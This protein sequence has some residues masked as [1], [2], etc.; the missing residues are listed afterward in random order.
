MI[1]ESCVI[2]QKKTLVCSKY[3][4]ILFTLAFAQNNLN[5]SIMFVVFA[6]ADSYHMYVQL[7]RDQR[8]RNPRYGY[9]SV[10]FMYNLPL[11]W[12]CAS[13]KN[14][15]TAHAVFL[16]AHHQGMTLICFDSFRDVF[17]YLLDCHS[18]FLFHMYKWV[19]KS[20]ELNVNSWITERFSQVLKT[21]CIF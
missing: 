12:K 14:H 2:G 1:R 20:W 9:L 15:G 7:I 4:T 19:I 21:H 6:Y 13:S 16:D 11:F 5:F 3:F 18:L 10:R 8:G 17:K